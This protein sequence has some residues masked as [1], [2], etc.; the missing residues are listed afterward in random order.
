V[1]IEFLESA[2]A[3]LDD[4]VGEVV[5]VGGVTIELWITDPGAPPP[6]PTLDV[7][8]VVQVTS[9][10]AF[11][12]FEAKLR[13]HGFREDQ[14][15]GVI[16][17]WRHRDSGLILDAM[18]ARADILGFEN[19]WQGAAIPH[20][21]ER[22]L[23]SGARIQ[24]ASPPYLLAMK[25]EAFK[26]RGRDDFVGSRDFADIVGLVDGRAELLTEAVDAD[27]ELREYIADE[28][29]QLLEH[30]RLMDGVAAGLRGDAGSQAR[31]DLVVLPALK[32]LAEM[33]TDSVR[34]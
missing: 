2:A 7:D 15:S 19:R 30:P 29:S 12:E 3:A 10:T 14:E 17:R 11:Y 16:C 6:R 22:R 34:D 1:S 25:L 5:F 20:A 26:G 33:R 18:P 21:V 31:A 9:R 23:P 32:R 24:A 28:I 8:V 4:L 27:E 13:A